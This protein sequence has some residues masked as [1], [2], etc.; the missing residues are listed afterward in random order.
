MRDVKQEIVRTF[1][2]QT[3]QRNS[4]DFTIKELCSICGISR[5]TFYKYFKD[6]YQI[7]EYVQQ[8]D[9]MEPIKKL[10]DSGVLSARPLSEIFYLNFYKNKD[11]YKAVIKAEGQNSF[12]DTL[13]T[14]ISEIVKL[15]FISQS[16][17]E[18]LDY[19]SYKFAAAIRS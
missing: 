14:R 2:E 5:P 15:T 8:E 1:I 16:D 3:K 13:I 19:I 7:I 6:K 9:L 10:I 12:V 17:K 18:A 4:I 11:F